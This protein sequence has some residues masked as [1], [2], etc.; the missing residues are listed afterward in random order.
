MSVPEPVKVLLA[1]GTYFGVS[2]AD[3]EFAIR[4]AVGLATILY[5]VSKTAKI[6]FKKKKETK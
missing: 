5:I 2:Q 1:A 6:W 4:S 3:I